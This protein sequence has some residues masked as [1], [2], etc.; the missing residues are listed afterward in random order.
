MSLGT[1]LSQAQELT[2]TIE[3]E[4]KQF[5]EEKDQ[6]AKEAQD[7]KEKV[8]ACLSLNAGLKKDKEKLQSDLDQARG[9]GEANERK[10]KD[11]KKELSDLEAKADRGQSRQKMALGKLNELRRKV[12]ILEDRLVK[13]KGAYYYNLAVAYS[14]AKFYDKAAQAY[15]QAL[16]HD[17]KNADAYYNLGLLNENIMAKPKEAIKN[18][19]QYLELNPKAEDKFKIE[20]R[21][22]RLELWY[23]Q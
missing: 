23:S 15:E 18:Y 20:D 16:L 21:I 12:A 10:L 9:D 22:E 17:P 8:T 7:A 13:E 14:H 3:G 6:L 1:Q 11:L 19:Q 2:A 4:Y 5:Q